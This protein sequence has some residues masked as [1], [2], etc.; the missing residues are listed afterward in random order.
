MNCVVNHIYD[1]CQFRILIAKSSKSQ[2]VIK[3]MK[4]KFVKVCHYKEYTV[5]NRVSDEHTLICKI[6]T[7]TFK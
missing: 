1:V 4:Y 7:V 2:F 6:E 3:L 5:T